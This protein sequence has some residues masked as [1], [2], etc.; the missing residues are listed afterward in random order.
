MTTI[1]AIR[2]GPSSTRSEQI[3]K[4]FEVVGHNKRR[5][6][7]CEQIFSSLAAAAHS[8]LVC[9]IGTGLSYSNAKNY[10]ADR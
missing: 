1:Q 4:V 8:E 7:V 3:G 2:P 10:Y 6:L 5:C 9:F